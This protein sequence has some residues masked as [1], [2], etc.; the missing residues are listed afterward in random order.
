V[1]ERKRSKRWRIAMKAVE[2]I[3]RQLR[4][5]SPYLA[6]ELLLPGG[7]IVALLLW[8]YRHRTAL[9][10]AAR[11]SPGQNDQLRRCYQ[12]TQDEPTR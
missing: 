7:S 8:T 11:R 10:L 4:S 9:Q 1:E 2:W 12:R 5:L 6:V 3:L